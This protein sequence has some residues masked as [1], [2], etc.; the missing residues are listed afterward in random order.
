MPCVQAHQCNSPYAE[1]DK[2]AYVVVVV[3]RQYPP[4]LHPQE[5]DDNGVESPQRSLRVVG[6]P[7]LVETLQICK[8]SQSTMHTHRKSLREDF[9]HFM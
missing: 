6:H 5:A 2:D 7:Q 8:E 3:V 1:S 4:G 9:K